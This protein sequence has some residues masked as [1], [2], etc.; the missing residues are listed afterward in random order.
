MDTLGILFQFLS[1]QIADNAIANDNISSYL[2]IA[3]TAIT[4]LVNGAGSSYAVQGDLSP[5]E[6][7]K[8]IDDLNINTI[9]KERILIAAVEVATTMALQKHITHHHGDINVYYQSQG[10]KVKQ[11]FADLSE[12]AGY[13]INAEDIA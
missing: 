10:I 7:M 9:E 11:E 2:D 1:D 5:H 3:S 4:G 8:E 12:R 6:L 13:P